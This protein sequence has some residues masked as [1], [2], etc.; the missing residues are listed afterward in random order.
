MANPV[1]MAALKNYVKSITLESN[2]FGPITIKDPFADKP[3]TGNAAMAALKPKLTVELWEEK[4]LTIAPAGEPNRGIQQA[5]KGVGAGVA[6]FGL[7][8]L[9][10]YLLSRKK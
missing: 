1:I 9:G 4:P 2:A 10:A 5:A 6:V 8:G 3:G 7:L